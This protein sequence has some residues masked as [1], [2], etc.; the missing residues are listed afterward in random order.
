[1]SDAMAGVINFISAP[2]LPAGTIEGN[3]LANYQANNGLIGY[4]LNLAGNE[5]DIIWDLRW[6]NKMA[7]DY[8]NNY[9]GYVLNSGFKEYT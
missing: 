2:T 7:H 6:S 1:G 5:K 4:S 8:K 3:V 9:D